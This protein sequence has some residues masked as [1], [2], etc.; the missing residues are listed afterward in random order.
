MNDEIK[1]HFSDLVNGLPVLA[2]LAFARQVL[3]EYMEN[4]L[5]VEDADT[6]MSQVLT[7]LTQ[8]DRVS[9]G[10]IEI[11]FFNDKLCQDRSFKKYIFDQFHGRHALY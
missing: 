7:L 8:L 11:L 1:F 6:R 10:T 5:L 3:R 2:N 4:R 9:D